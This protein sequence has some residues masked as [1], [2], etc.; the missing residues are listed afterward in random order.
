MLSV[1]A[2]TGTAL[3]SLHER[4]GEAALRDPRR[5]PVGYLAADGET[6]A[7]APFLWF[8]DQAEMLRFVGTVEP[9]LLRLAPLVHVEVLDALG[10]LAR[11]ER[12]LDRLAP[13]LTVAFRGWTEFP[14]VGTFGELC[15][16]DGEI[17]AELRCTLRGRDS[18]VALGPDEIPQMVELLRSIAHACGAPLVGGA[19]GAKEARTNGRVTEPAMKEAA[20]RSSG[21]ETAHERM[22]P[23]ATRF[24][25]RAP[26]RRAHCVSETKP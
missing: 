24:G 5:F 3:R 2:G 15:G 1:V 25:P 12:G 9:G 20:A 23:I 13:G 4:Y 21:R 17:V 14:W 26:C 19:P 22:K 10:A 8:R 16:G 11:R 18:D 7:V 6:G